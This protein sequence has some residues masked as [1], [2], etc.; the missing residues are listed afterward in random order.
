MLAFVNRLLALIISCLAL[1]ATPISVRAKQQRVPLFARSCR[2][3]DTSPIAFEDALN[4][5]AWSCGGRP[6]AGDEASHVW[7]RFDTKG[8]LNGAIALSGM[9]APVQSIELV[10]V[11]PR[12]A[13][14][15]QSIT[16]IDIIANWTSGNTF[17]VALNF[18]ISKIEKVRQA[19]SDL[20]ARHISGLTERVTASGGIAFV[21]VSAKNALCAADLALNHAKGAGRNQLMLASET[22]LVAPERFDLRCAA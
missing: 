10:A 11:T 13:R 17:A 1:L 3:N 22:T 9:P 4:S 15:H 21:Q 6:F 2:L 5:N 18:N 7:L 20:V 16:E 14:I 19:I 8:A 12:K